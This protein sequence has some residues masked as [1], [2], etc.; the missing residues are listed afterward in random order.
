MTKIKGVGKIMCAKSDVQ[1]FGSYSTYCHA[2][3]GSPDR[4]LVLF[5]TM[6]SA[7]SAAHALSLASTANIAAQQITSLRVHNQRS[8]SKEIR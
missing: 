5:G 3:P 4:V 6:S 7:V 1:I 2:F 8:A